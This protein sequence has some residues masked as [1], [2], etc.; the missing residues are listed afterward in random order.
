MVDEETRTGKQPTS[1]DNETDLNKKDNMGS[2]N[3][4]RHELYD[5]K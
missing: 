1:R 4:P 5:N 3:G 2:G